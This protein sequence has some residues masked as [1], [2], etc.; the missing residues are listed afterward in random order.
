LQR[1]EQA[2]TR[3]P[4]LSQTTQIQNEAMGLRQVEQT[5]DPAIAGQAT[6]SFI[7]I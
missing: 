7:G 1:V 2:K 3:S 4:A 5:G 6:S